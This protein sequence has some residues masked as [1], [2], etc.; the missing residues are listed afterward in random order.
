MAIWTSNGG[1]FIHCCS[2][3]CVTT[4]MIILEFLFLQETGAT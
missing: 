1:A 3:D 4:E 2:L